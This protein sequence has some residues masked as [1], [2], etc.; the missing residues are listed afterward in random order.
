MKFDEPM[1]PVD[2]QYLLRKKGVT[3]KALAR[4]LGVAEMTMSQVVNFKMTSAPLMK[5]VADVIGMSP[6][7]VF[8]ARLNRPRLRPRRG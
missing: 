5:A 3:Q 8:A 2:I 1:T 6:E 4:R 7:V